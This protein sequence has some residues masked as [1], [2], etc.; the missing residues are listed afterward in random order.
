MQKIFLIL[1]FALLLHANDRIIALSPAINE[2][3]YALDGGEKIVGNTEFCTYPKR[4]KNKPKVGGY[5]SP[6]LEKILEL[7]PTLVMMQQSGKNFSKK[8]NKLGIK[9]QLFKLTTLQDIEDTIFRIGKILEKS[10]RSKEILDSINN[11]LKQIKNI[12]TNKK[13]LIVIGHPLKL[14][15]QIFVVGNNLYLNDIINLSNNQNAFKQKKTGQPILNM[16]NIIASDPQIVIILAPYTKK[17]NLTKQQLIAPWLK[18]PIKAA[19]TKTVYVIDKEYAGI[20]SHRLTYFLRDFK[21]IL[22]DA[23]SR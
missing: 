20:S 16:E 4:T 11:R 8:L 12:S 22:E 2:I 14:D 17:K 5:F 10:K 18:L 6:N 7:K 1:L 21:E 15:K 13:I 3:I 19:K 9:T 23:K